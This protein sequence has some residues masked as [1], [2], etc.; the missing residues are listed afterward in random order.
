MSK[1]RQT[2]FFL[3]V[4]PMDKNHKDPDTIDLNDIHFCADG[5][6]VETVFRTIISVDQLSVYGAVSD[7][8]EEY[9]ICQTGTGRL[10]V[11]EQ[12]EPSFAPAGSLVTTPTPSIEILAQENL[13]QKHKERLERLPQQD[14]LIKIVLMQDP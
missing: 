8:C 10:V 1:E 4:D 9:S 3:P 7:L 6:T 12:S 14:R 5:D 13:L 11:A 2:V